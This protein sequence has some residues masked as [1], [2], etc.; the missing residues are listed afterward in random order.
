MSWGAALGGLFA[1]GLSYLGQSE[2]NQANANLNR[3]NREWQMYMSN[4]A[5]QR[6]VADL[7]A[8]GLNPILSAGGGGASSP[9][10]GVPVMQNAL[11]RLGE[12]V[13]DAIS[14]TLEA[15]RTSAEVKAVN[16][17]A[18]KAASDVDV[19]VKTGGLIDA[20]T[21]EATARAAMQENLLQ[22]SGIMKKAW[23]YIGN[24]AKGI[25][26]SPGEDLQNATRGLIQTIQNGAK[27]PFELQIKRG[28]E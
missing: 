6:E 23:E 28:T 26:S 20:Q 16:A 8:A 4:T 22:R 17:N 5:H 19:N 12:G 25:G 18:L 2:A 27:R 7:R 15:R 24:A 9:S 14:K 3:E 21:R 10:G 1:G 11:G 13:S